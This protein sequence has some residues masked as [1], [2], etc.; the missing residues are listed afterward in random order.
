LPVTCCC[1]LHDST[2]TRAAD[3][4][5]S[6][7]ARRH[8]LTCLAAPRAG[9]LLLPAGVEALFSGTRPI[10]YDA[11]LE[12]KPYRWAGLAGRSS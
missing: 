7:A 6:G 10:V 9:A 12:T 8:Q 5:S 11:L 4:H 1:K 2:G 3:A